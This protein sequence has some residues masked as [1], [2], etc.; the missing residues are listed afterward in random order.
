MIEIY[1]SGHKYFDKTKVKYTLNLN[2]LH[3]HC[4]IIGR[5]IYIP[6]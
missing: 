4:G 6:F 3:V 2:L 5:V 1:T